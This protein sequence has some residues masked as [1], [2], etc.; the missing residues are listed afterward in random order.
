MM[1]LGRCSPA[2]GSDVCNALWTIADN[3]SVCAAVIIA[4]VQTVNEVLLI[5]DPQPN[6]DYRTIPRTAPSP[7]A[8]QVVDNYNALSTT[9]RL[10]PKKDHSFAGPLAHALRMPSSL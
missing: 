3:W 4:A 5:A 1:P 9:I 7:S 10:Y 2:A 8:L 6:R